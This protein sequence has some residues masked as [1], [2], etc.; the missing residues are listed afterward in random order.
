M[1][2]PVKK[3]ICKC[4]RHSIKIR[5]KAHNL[6]TPKKREKLSKIAVDSLL[7]YPAKGKVGGFGVAFQKH[8]ELLFTLGILL[9]DATLNE[10]NTCHAEIY[11]SLVK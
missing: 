7:F 5:H 11:V 10:D 8:I 6:T 9:D 2:L 4:G 3:N 1:I